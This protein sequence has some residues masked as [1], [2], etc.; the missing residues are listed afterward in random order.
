MNS[1]RPLALVT[2]EPAPGSIDPLLDAA[3]VARI[4]GVRSKRVYE[5][6][7]PYVKLG[8][9][10]YRWALGDVRRWI[11]DHTNNRR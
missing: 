11:E 6:G 2:H 9:R 5:L 4:L 3:T 1:D 10:Q 7:I 8:T